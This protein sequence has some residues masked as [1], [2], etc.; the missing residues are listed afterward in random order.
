[1]ENQ[2]TETQN[3]TLNHGSTTELVLDYKAMEQMHNLASLM[4]SGAS[5]VPRH[6]QGN[7]ADC[8]AVVMQAAQWKMNPYSVAQKTHLVNGQLGYEAQ[9]VNA[10][11]SSSTAIAGSFHYE[12]FGDWS[13]VIGNFQT[14]KN[15]S[16]KTYQ[17]PAW[18]QED[19]K[20]L[21]VRVWATLRGESEPRVLELLLSQAQVRNSTLWASDPKQQL[22][23]LGV[24]RW[25]RLYCPAVILGVYTSDELQEVAPVEREI[26]P[27]QAP[28][29]ETKSEALNGALSGDAGAAD[30]LSSSAVDF[31]VAIESADSVDVLN[32]LSQEISAAVSSGSLSDFDR[33]QLFDAYKAQKKA[34]EVEAV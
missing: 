31:M 2:I 16:G 18:T 13:R 8:M 33:G 4:A 9:L 1:M 14:K 30:E 20:G 29:V 19:E 24:K 21:G 15:G 22:A 23:Y 28:K 10:V 7:A 32:E 25:A 3:Q 5:T 11:I 34:L 27:R 17:A 26:N 6:L 12:W